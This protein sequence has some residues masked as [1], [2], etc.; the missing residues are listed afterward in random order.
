MSPGPVGRLPPIST[1]ASHAV[2]A[3]ADKDD[4]VTIRPSGSLEQRRDI[5]DRPQPGR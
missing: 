1:S 3:A 5:L 2:N 4:P